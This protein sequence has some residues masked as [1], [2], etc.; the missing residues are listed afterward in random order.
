MKSFGS[1]FGN[2]ICDSK[3]IQDIIDG[4]IIS[5]NIDKPNSKLDITVAFPHFVERRMIF[6]A[7]KQLIKSDL[8][9]DIVNI[10]PR[11]KSSEFKPEYCYDIIER[12]G[13]K[14]KSI[15]G[16]IKNADICI[17]EDK[18]IINLKNGGNDIL[19]NR[20]FDKI[21]SSIIKDEFGVNLKV[22]FEGT[23]KVDENSCNYI[24]ENKIRLEKEKRENI[25]EEIEIYESKM[26]EKETKKKKTVIDNN[27]ISVRN[28]IDFIP[29]VIL[30][31]L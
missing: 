21:L 16:I 9:V 5:I 31:T 6:N 11:F 10:F 19:I 22:L 28:G 8:N 3:S 17:N 18:I 26:E 2:Y 24:N 29:Q 13:K 25:I 7:E 15:N 1:L 20:K 12:L 30:S 14:N 23:L 27:S 4:E